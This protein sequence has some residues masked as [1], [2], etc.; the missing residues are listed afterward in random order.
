MT[1]IRIY[2]NRKR[3][4]TR[5][6]SSLNTEHSQLK[7]KIKIYKATV[8]LFASRCRIRKTKSTTAKI[9]K[10]HILEYGN[11]GQDI[12]RK[13]LSTDVGLS[14]NDKNIDVNRV[15]PMLSLILEKFKNRHN[16]FNYFDKLKHMTTRNNSQ[17]EYQISKCSLK[18]F[19]NLL[20]YENVP[21]ELFGTSQN[22]KVIK[23][24]IHHLLETVPGKIFITRAFKRKV[25]RVDAVGASLNIQPLFDKFDIYNIKWLHSIDSDTK[26]WIIILKLLH[27]FFAQYIIK[28]LHKYIVVISVKG[29]WVYIA[30]DDWCKKQEKF[31]NDRKSTCLVPYKPVE[32]RSIW[33]IP[34]RRYK[35][36]PTASG[37]RA[38]SIAR[39]NVKKK[40]DDVDVVLRFLQQLY[41][42]YFNENGIPTMSSCNAA[43]TKFGI[44]NRNKK[45]C[46]VRCDVQ[47]AFGS[48]KQ[49]KL[50]DIIKTICRKV[51]IYLSL[52]TYILPTKK[53]TKGIQTVQFLT[54]KK[55]IHKQARVNKE[56]KPKFV[57]KTKLI[58]KIKKLK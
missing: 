1:L 23:K 18:S 58:A 36:I 43:I 46:F 45:L 10:Y 57:K 31:I 29:Q 7:S 49:D 11:T 5:K 15:I 26:K 40:F 9:S 39:Y 54:L 35:F 47:D 6:T 37:L 33:Y 25:Q 2:D 4:Y 53:K 22:L 52:R 8:N 20:V 48:I 16:R 14:K 27:W 30:K 34:I 21:L 32:H 12:C 38:L 17:P 3:R 41:V 44:L 24:T 13:I 56:E 55:C 28:I 50:Y 42:T 51:P 19:F